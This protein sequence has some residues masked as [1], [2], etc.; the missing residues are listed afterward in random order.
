MSFF[1]IFAVSERQ[2]ESMVLERTV[3]GFGAALAHLIVCLTNQLD[4]ANVIMG[5]PEQKPFT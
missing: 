1:G 2:P 3:D 4:S 5:F